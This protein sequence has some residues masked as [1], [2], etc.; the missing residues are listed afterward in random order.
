M[1]KKKRIPRYVRVDSL[2]AW[3]VM[4]VLTQSSP[5]SQLLVCD[6]EHGHIALIECEGGPWFIKDN[7]A[8]VAR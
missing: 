7:K 3:D 4:S 6:S 8:R 2:S 5:K 1:K